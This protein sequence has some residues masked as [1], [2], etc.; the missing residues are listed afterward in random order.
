MGPLIGPTADA[1]RQLLALRR[2]NGTN[3]RR[4]CFGQR[5]NSTRGQVK[6]IE[7]QTSRR[8]QPRRCHKRHLPPV[9]RHADIRSDALAD[10]RHLAGARAVRSPYLCAFRTDR[11]EVEGVSD[12]PA[13][14]N[15]REGVA[16]R[17]AGKYALLTWSIYR[18]CNELE[19][20]FF[21]R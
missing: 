8:A 15:Q 17:C 2:P 20:P 13:Q 9:R 7:R 21:A 11:Y 18:Q 3:D 16:A 19:P 4:G 5:T 10:R 12:A 14:W 6:H 1:V